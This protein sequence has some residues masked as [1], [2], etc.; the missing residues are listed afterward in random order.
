M[1][2][3]R[4]ALGLSLVRA[5][6]KWR[7]RVNK[8]VLAQ[9]Q[10]GLTFDNPVGLAAGFD[11]NAEHFNKLSALGFGF[12]E[13]G[14]VTGKGQ[15]GNSRPRMFRLPA[16]AGLLNRMGF[17]NH[18]SSAVAARLTRKRI[19]PLLGVNIGKTKKV[20][21]KDAP[22]DYEESFRRL[23]DFARYFVVNVSSPNTPGL[24][25]LQSKGPLTELLNHLQQV[26]ADV[27]A[28]KGVS[29]RPIL[30]KIAPD[31]TDGQL[32]DILEVVEA[33]RI[34]GIIAT[35]TTIE[36]ADLNTPGQQDLGSGGV[37]G[38]PVRKRSLELIRQIY[39]RTDGE[40]PI[41]GVGG[42]FDAAD[43][44]E[45]IRAGASL[46]QVWTGFV[47][48]GPGMVRRINQGLVSACKEHGWKHISEAVG[49]DTKH[50]ALP[51]AAR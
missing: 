35:N 27:A 21:L 41:I 34:D 7:C 3:L 17:N 15:P 10:W 37:S 23:F 39:A 43:A 25:S 6:I 31:I 40:L 1:N 51:E 38:K 44:L 16:D 14:T 28:N 47:Y 36:R 32:E 42:I 24:R 46:V 4:L 20:A 5:V 45:T 13:I 8:T 26:N 29:R 19:E 48:E 9:T 33:C 49:L 22:A 50:D 12:I 18:G 2:L 30:L 11:K